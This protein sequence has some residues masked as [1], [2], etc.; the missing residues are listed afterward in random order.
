MMRSDLGP[1]GKEEA[2]AP[3]GAG[4]H[5]HQPPSPLQ[6]TESRSHHMGGVGVGDGRYTRGLR[7]GFDRGAQDALRLMGRRCHC[8]DCAAEVE[9]LAD[10]YR[11]AADRRAS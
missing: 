9:K 7:D 5:H 8:L 2:G 11:G 4:P 6:K 1:P 3:P 10:Y